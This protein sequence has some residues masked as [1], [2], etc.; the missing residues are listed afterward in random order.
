MW[1]LQEIA[2]IDF[3]EIVLLY[4][5]RNDSTFSKF[6]NDT[7]PDPDLSTQLTTLRRFS[8]PQTEQWFQNYLELLDYRRVYGHCLVP[9]KY[10]SNA[11]LGH[12]VK[13]Q[14]YQHKMRR[15]G[16]NS[17]LTYER[18]RLLNEIGFVRD[19]HGLSW[20]ER[21]REL[22]HFKRI[23]EHCSV[24]TNYNVNPK[25]ASWVKAQRHQQKPIRF[26]ERSTM[27]EDR[28]RTLDVLA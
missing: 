24:P 18:L 7:N 25:L 15:A 16:R 27:T 20:E 12:R 6:L 11:A 14:R 21:L 2:T 4:P 3:K 17:T 8:S 5:S 22:L 28:I 9:F 10:A 19:S 13:R 26:G 1:G 23:H